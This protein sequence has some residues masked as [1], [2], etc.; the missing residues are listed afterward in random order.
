L[1]NGIVGEKFVTR[2]TL[3]SGLLDAFVIVELELH[4]GR[5]TKRACLGDTTYMGILG[6]LGPTPFGCCLL[7]EGCENNQLLM[8]LRILYKRSTRYSASAM[9]LEDYELLCNVWNNGY[10]LTN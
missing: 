5:A 4:I 3:V 9:K 7:H 8:N 2:Q 6:H 1:G 10:G